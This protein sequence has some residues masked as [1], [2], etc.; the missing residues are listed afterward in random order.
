MKLNLRLSPFNIRSIYKQLVDSK[1]T[2]FCKKKIISD[3]PKKAVWFG[4]VSRKQIK[5]S[6]QNYN[7]IL[8]HFR[9]V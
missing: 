1:I 6:E 8:E 2:L 7:N 4:K 9:D 5:T 3:L